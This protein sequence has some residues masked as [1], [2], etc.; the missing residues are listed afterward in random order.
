MLSGFAAR[1]RGSVV[2]TIP[3]QNALLFI[4]LGVGRLFP[5]SDR[6]PQIQPISPKKL[7]R[8]IDGE[9][10]LAGFRMGRTDRVDTGFYISQAMELVRA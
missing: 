3:P 7:G 1:T 4:K 9:A 10:S 2:F 6:S 5:R 8:L